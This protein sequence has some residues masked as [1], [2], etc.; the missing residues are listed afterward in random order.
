MIFFLIVFCA[1]DFDV[2]ISYFGD[3]LSSLQEALF[4]IVQTQEPHL[5]SKLSKLPCESVYEDKGINRK[6]NG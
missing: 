4:P 5:F 3:H 2:Y 6:K 1:L